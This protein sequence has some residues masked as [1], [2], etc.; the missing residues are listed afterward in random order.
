MYGICEINNRDYLFSLNL[1][2]TKQD[3]HRIKKF[4]NFAGELSSNTSA[5]LLSWIEWDS[6]YMPWEKND[7][8]FAEIDLIIDYSK[9]PRQGPTMKINRDLRE[10]CGNENKK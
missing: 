10:K 1:K 6:P 4:R 7:L 5:N 8:F 2:K 3:I 9:P